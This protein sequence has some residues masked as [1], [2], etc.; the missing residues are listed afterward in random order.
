MCGR[1]ISNSEA[2]VME[3]RE[4]LKLISMRFVLAEY[5]AALAEVFPTNR[6]TIINSLEPLY[7]KWGIE[8]WDKKGVI[9]N[10]RSE[11]YE[12]SGFFKHFAKNRCIIPA[13]GYYE[14]RKGEGKTKIK[15]AF[16]GGDNHGIFMAGIIKPTPEQAE[17]AIITKPAEPEIHFVHDRMPVIVRA[18]Q[19]GG[20]L[21]G[22]LPMRELCAMNSGIVWEKA[23]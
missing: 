11:T 4:I 1:Y 9:I 12:N 22:Q 7:A 19:V 2:E 10:A 16:T 6:V 5:P 13:H 15:Y 14:W 20:W 17:F 18:E 21:S 8:K 23:G 3:I